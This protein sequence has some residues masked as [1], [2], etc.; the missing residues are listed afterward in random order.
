[1]SFRHP[2]YGES[3]NKKFAIIMRN[4]K[5]FI[6]SL[7]FIL[8]FSACSS[9]TQNRNERSGL[10][11]PVV[12]YDKISLPKVERH[13][14]DTHSLRIVIDRNGE[15]SI[16]RCE[17]DLSTIKS[18]IMKMQDDNNNLSN[19]YPPAIIIGADSNT[20]FEKILPV[21][22]ICHEAGIN[23]ICFG[24]ADENNGYMNITPVSIISNPP[25]EDQ[26]LKIKKLKPLIIKLKT[27]GTYIGDKKIDIANIFDKVSASPLSEKTYDFFHSINRD[28]PIIF[29]PSKETKYDVISKS[30]FYCWYFMFMNLSILDEETLKSLGLNE[31][32]MSEQVDSPNGE[33]P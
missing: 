26:V 31:Q 11:I 28:Q 18:I 12:E 30:V 24:V 8:L 4:M 1:M 33:A 6:S 17:I 25:G 32:Y 5:I 22:E 9:I 13:N 16:Y 21:M 15:L 14:F 2:A 27:D 7:F 20:V 19:H 3:Y 29:V 10:I 23:K